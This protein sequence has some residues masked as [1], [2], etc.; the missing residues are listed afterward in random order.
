MPA[1]TAEYGTWKHAVGAQEKSGKHPSHVLCGY[2]FDRVLAARFSQQ[3][4]AAAY[5]GR[6]GYRWIQMYDELEPV[7]SSHWTCES[8]AFLRHS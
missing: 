7:F 5:A 6:D 4:P 1:S 8:E 2:G 3:P